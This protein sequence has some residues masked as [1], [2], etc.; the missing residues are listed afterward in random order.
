[1]FARDVFSVKGCE[2]YE[3]ENVYLMCLY[4]RSIEKSLIPFSMEKSR[5]ALYND[6]PME[7]NVP[8]YFILK[9]F[10]ALI[11]KLCWFTLNNIY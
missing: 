3:Y 6:N 10:F 9:A 11:V 4:S 7:N 1:M 8:L 5:K 2:L